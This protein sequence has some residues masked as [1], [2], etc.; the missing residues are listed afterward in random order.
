[1]LHKCAGTIIRSALPFVT[2]RVDF[3]AELTLL[4]FSAREAN[5]S[6][7]ERCAHID[8]LQTQLPTLPDSD[9]YSEYSDGKRPRLTRRFTI[10]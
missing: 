1:M 8:R 4:R 2:R 9:V 5:R 3:G 10:S 6:G 7:V